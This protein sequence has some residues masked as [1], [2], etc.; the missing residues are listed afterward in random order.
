MCDIGS[1]EFSETVTV[2][3]L[4]SVARTAGGDC[5]RLRTLVRVSV[6]R[7]VYE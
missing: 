3:V 7:K 2:S 5:N 6:I 4:K 1:V